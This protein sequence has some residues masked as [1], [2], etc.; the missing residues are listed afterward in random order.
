[1]RGT[2]SGMDRGK[3]AFVLGGGGHLGAHEVGMLRALLERGITPDLVVGTSIGAINGAAVAADPT[4][5][6]VERL[7]TTWREVARGDVFGSSVLGRIG[8]LA[9]TRTHLHDNEGLRQLL[10]R[11]APVERI[12]ELPV[13]FEC[14]AA[15]IETA[16]EHWFT[17]G[18][19]VEA[20]LA[21][22]A[23]PGILPP[24]EIGGEH[25][26]DGGIVNSIPVGRAVQHGATTIYVMHVGRVDRPLEPPRWPWEV[27]LVAF[28]IARRHRFMGDMAALP[29]GLDVHVLPTG[30]SDP[31]RYT[32]L[33]Q[34]RYRDTSK[35][36]DL[37]ER[38]FEASAAYLE[39][40]A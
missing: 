31:P 28:E 33:S 2:L 5:A 18:P 26:L 11:A 20:V 24:V 40:V 17:E 23:V 9:R 13:A 19:L 10:V 25:F 12:E 37:I 36:P 6:A 15:C 30:D 14:V 34:F 22:C 7:S 39:R 16:S 35:V 32:D 4:P 3:V 38:A 29:D 8:T 21:S 27:G 1:M